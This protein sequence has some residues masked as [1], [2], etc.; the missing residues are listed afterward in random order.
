MRAPANIRPFQGQ[1]LVEMLPADA[2]SHAGLSI[3]DK[4]KEKPQQGIVRRIGAWKQARK[5]RGLIPYDFKVGDKV[6]I[7]RRT[8]G[9]Q[10]DRH[11]GERFKIVKA[12][13][14][15]AI[16]TDQAP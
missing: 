13:Q 2:F 12:E 6:V 8:W 15:V 11:I 16:V 5:S 4:A 9:H 1:V 10:L 14:V 7:D 3:P